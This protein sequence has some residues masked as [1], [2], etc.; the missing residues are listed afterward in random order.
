[1][2]ASQEI[3]VAQ[4]PLA[5]QRLFK[6]LGMF[7]PRP[8][9]QKAAI[10]SLPFEGRVSQ[11]PVVGVVNRPVRCGGSQPGMLG[12]RTPWPLCG[13]VDIM[14]LRGQTIKPDQPG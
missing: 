8:L 6:T 10:A 14:V 7:L 3:L 12:R 4:C 13:V 2:N 9:F 1:M 5:E 11:M